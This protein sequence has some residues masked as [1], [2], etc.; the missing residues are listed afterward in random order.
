M[1]ILS[2]FFLILSLVA[3]GTNTSQ[4]LAENELVPLPTQSEDIPWPTQSWPI[5]ETPTALEATLDRI[6][7]GI[8]PGTPTNTRALLVVKEGQLIGERYGPG[9]NSE[10]HFQSWSMAKSVVHALIGILLRDGQIDLQAPAKVARWHR[11]VRD[12]RTVITIEDL[13]RMQ[14]G[15]TFSESYTDPGASNVLQMLFGSGRLDTA[16]YAAGHPLEAEPGTH[17]QY[18]SGSTNILSGVIRDTIAAKSAED[19]RRFIDDSLLRRIG[20][21]NAVPEFDAANTFIGSSYIHMSARDW[22]RFG[23]LY[24]RDGKWENT[25]V[26]PEGWADHAR[27]PTPDSKGQYGA[28][29]WLNAIDPT[30]G[31]AVISDRVP[32]DAFMA[33][34]YGAQVALIIPSLDMIIVY[35]GLTYDDPTPIVNA[36][37]DIVEAAQ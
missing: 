13:I 30:T 4:A 22:A 6:I 36:I 37:A 20:I 21:E 18:S 33:R 25:Q 29:F 15:L 11:K 35:L 3:M 12:P 10:S 8:E 26:L 9:F 19:Y 5:G 7:Q 31:H 24:L 28:H 34:G 27:T 2:R 1:S 16:E 17:W 32:T 14:S 23:L